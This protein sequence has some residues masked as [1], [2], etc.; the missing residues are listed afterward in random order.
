MTVSTV[1]RLVPR[2]QQRVSNRNTKCVLQVQKPGLS[3]NLVLTQQ[4]TG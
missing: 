4:V 2:P 3:V 1:G